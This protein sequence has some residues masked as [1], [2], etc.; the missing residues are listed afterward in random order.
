MEID[1]SMEIN[2]NCPVCGK[3][4]QHLGEMDSPSEEPRIVSEYICNECETIVTISTKN[5]D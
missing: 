4:M 2:T 5:G 3:P 1:N